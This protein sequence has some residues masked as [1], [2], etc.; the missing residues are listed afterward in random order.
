LDDPAKTHPVHAT[1]EQIEALAKSSQLSD[2][3]SEID[4]PRRHALDRIFYVISDARKRVARLK[5]VRAN[6]SVFSNINNSAQSIR[7]ELE[8]YISNKNLG[9]IDNAVS[10]TDQGLALHVEQLPSG[11]LAAEAETALEGFRKSSRSAIGELKANEGILK[12]QIAKL[13]QTIGVQEER[14]AQA[15]SE[16]ETSKQDLANAVSTN[17]SNFNSMKTSLESEFTKLREAQG[18]ALEKQLQSSPSLANR[19]IAELDEKKKEAA[20]IA[21]SV[22]DILTTG[23]WRRLKPKPT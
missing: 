20:A 16:I 15:Q 8:N 5:G 1:L 2:L 4:E 14:I 9:H 18:A 3:N 17:D 6:L 11:S 13:E 19:R 22:G 7:Q 21:Q 10:Q 23:T 12:Q